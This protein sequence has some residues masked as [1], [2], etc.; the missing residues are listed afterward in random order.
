MSKLRVT[1]VLA[2]AALCVTGATAANAQ[3]NRDQVVGQVVVRRRPRAF[4]GR[5]AD[6]AQIH[7]DD[8]EVLR[9]RLLV[10]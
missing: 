3:A 7:R 8:A 6:P 4:V 1:S 9:Q 10:P 2:L 5:G